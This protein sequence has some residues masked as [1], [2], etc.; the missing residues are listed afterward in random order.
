MD[1]RI[2]NQTTVLRLAVG[3][4]ATLAGIDKFF[5]ILTDWSHYV[6]PVATQW[7]PFSTDVLMWIVGIVEFAVGVSILTAWPV[8]GAFVASAWLLLISLNLLVGGY[9]DI[10]VRDVVLAISAF[11]LARL[12]Q[13]RDEVEVREASPDSVRHH[14]IA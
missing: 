11:T 5:N 12:I 2:Q 6:S 8:I 4:M 1:T 7:L 14:R 10:A 9:F 13:V 3:L